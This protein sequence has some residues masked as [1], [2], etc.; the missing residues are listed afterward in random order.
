VATETGQR[1][2]RRLAWLALGSAILVSAITVAAS[3]SADVRVAQERVSGRSEVMRTRLGQLEYAVSGHGP[4]LLMIHGT[5]GGFDQSLTFTEALVKRGHR[6][7][8]PS[9]FG[10]LGRD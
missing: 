10:Y 8:A 6:V 3:F 9:R 4:P 1:R 5:G 7:I 2:R